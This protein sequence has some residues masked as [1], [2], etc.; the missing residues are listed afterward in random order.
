MPLRPTR[1]PTRHVRALSLGLAPAILGLAL[2]LLPVGH[3]LEERFGLPVLFV[4]RGERSPPADVVIVSLDRPSAALLDLPND[5]ARWPRTLHADLVTRLSDAGASLIAFDIV[6][7]EPGAPEDDARLADAM[8]RA[9]TVVLARYLQRGTAPPE[10]SVERVV[11]PVPVL[12]AAAAGSAPFPLPK[13]PV[14]VSQ[15]WTFKAGAG[16][17]PTLP[18]V[19]LQVLARDAYPDLLRLLAAAG[20]PGLDALP[21]TGSDLLA[22]G[23]VEET[24]RRVRE[25]VGAAPDAAARARAMLAARPADPGARGRLEALADLYLGGESRYLEFYGPAGT[26]TTVPYH[27]AVAAQ[28]PLDLAG[29]AV[30]VGASEFLRP[31][32]R[33][34]FYTVY[35]A[36]DGVDLSGVEIAATALAN[37]LEG[38]SI[39]PLAALPH[40]LLLLGVG[41]GLGW[42]GARLAPLPAVVAVLFATGFY[43]AGAALLFESRGLWLPL[44]APVALQTPLAI[45]GAT[46]YRYTEVNRERE[47]L[48]VSFAY[49]LPERE[50]DALVGRL[51]APRERLEQVYG[52]CLSTDVQGYTRFSETMAPVDLARVVNLYL[53]TVFAP[54][55]RAGGVISDIKGDSVLGL[56]AAAAPDA[57]MRAR[58][59]RAAFEVAAAVSEPGLGPA[60]LAWP[61]RFGLHAGLCA[62]GHVGALDHYEYRPVGD[63]VNTA[64]HVQLLNKHLGTRILV[65]AELLEGV[66]AF[67]TR[68]MGAFLLFGKTRPVVVHELIG[69][70]DAA[71]PGRLEAVAR[72]GDALGA[73]RRG[74]LDEARRAF[75]ALGQ[76]GDPSAAFYVGQ[77]GLRMAARENGDLDGVFR[78]EAK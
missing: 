78:V 37:L 5:P 61:T 44:V 31:E 52:V 76:A 48:R 21:R 7:G 10:V 56:W 51:G 43:L 41:F 33:D 58:A 11:P 67:L 66:R 64:N 69:P 20:V 54:I 4:M 38:R 24:V 72:F 6:F 27:L 12:A 42:L 36:Q 47:R 1:P 65:S 40:L 57:G 60:G 53:A 28:V 70:R 15:Y 32:Q 68:E 17:A 49:Y 34:A 39:R 22:A 74:A 29:K 8:R 23:P 2:G 35:S 25:A 13:V 63:M 59:C 9:G 19:A 45:L 73:Y 46:L 55:R 62:L 30:F 26:I 3:D 75:E 14:R 77:C 18:V 71:D 16:D 50:I